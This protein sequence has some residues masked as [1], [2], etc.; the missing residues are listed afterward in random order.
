[1]AQALRRVGSAPGGAV[2]PVGCP[3]SGWFEPGDT[4]AHPDPF[5]WYQ[6]LRG[7]GPVVFVPATAAGDVYV[8]TR[9]KEISE[10]LRDPINYSNA[11]GLGEF[12][13]V[14]RSI[15]EEAGND[16]RYPI[17]HTLTLTDPPQHTRL[18]KLTAPSFTPRRLASFEPAIREI[19]E[20]RIDAI[21]AQGHAD[22][23][24][25]YMYQIPNRVIARIMGAEEAAAERFVEWVEA[26]LLLAMTGK[27]LSE[28]EAAESW[29]LLLEQDRY[30]RALVEERRRCPANDL[31]TDM[32][33]ARTDDGDPVL[34]DD[35]ILSNTLGFIGAGSEST[36]I[37]MTNTMYLLLTHPE[38]FAEVRD[39]PELIPIAFEEA[40]RLLGPVRG[41]IRVAKTEM[42]LGGVRIPKGARLY[43]SVMSA[44]HDER[45]FEQPEK[46]DL[47]R[48]DNREHLGFG[49]WAHFC[50]GAPLARLEGR[51]AIET[52][53]SRLP[54]LR[55]A[56]GAAEAYGFHDNFITP[57]VKPLGVEW[58]L[59]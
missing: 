47:H 53:I 52:L 25:D 31:T 12:P 51:I 40:L 22:L 57:P 7:E 56:A 43:L 41:L 37:M 48:R 58:D 4:S 26:F 19:A 15:R 38:E 20:A 42:E 27:S 32:I 24:A 36:A 59:A 46:F 23:A 39:N 55:L 13:E 30:C 28:D 44:N 54:N 6:R 17:E 3:V 45:M 11:M 2:A 14:P 35:E 21:A 8:L 49:R 33:Q 50:V 1:M 10:V 34:T 29:Q 9:Y 18:R 16:W 5:P